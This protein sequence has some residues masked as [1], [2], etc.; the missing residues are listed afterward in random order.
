MRCSISPWTSAGCEA[1][2]AL[3]DCTVTEPHLWQPK[4]YLAPVEAR[5]EECGH[6]FVPDV[7]CWEELAAWW[8]PHRRGANKP[9]WDL[10]VACNLGGV[11]GLA[12]V[13]GKAHEQE[14]GRFGKP[15]D[16]AGSP[17]S[18][19]NHERIGEAIAEASAA[20]DRVLP[21]VLLSRDSHYQLANRVAYS[22]RLASMG[23]P[24]LLMYL[25]FTGDHGISYV[26]TPLRDGLHWQSA[27]RG[28][29]AGVLPDGFL[30]R[31]IPCGKAGMRMIVRSKAVFEQS[32]PS[33]RY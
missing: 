12:L 7:E 9:N 14:L 2:V 23:V 10:V 30:E 11:P 16:P 17:N 13:E 8:I 27:M 18:L 33:S 24:V 26:G 25:G 29:M 4:G 32:S 31:W 21:G 19:A 5:L 3:P 15:F 20:L 22:W 1:L 28:Y 6:H